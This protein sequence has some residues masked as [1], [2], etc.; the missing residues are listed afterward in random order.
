MEMYGTWSRHGSAGNWEKVSEAEA[1]LEEQR[2][3]DLSE[4]EMD[5]SK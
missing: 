5:L 4:I 2:E 1:P 3:V